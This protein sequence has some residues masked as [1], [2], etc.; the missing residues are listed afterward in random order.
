MEKNWYPR[1]L[2]APK[3]DTNMDNLDDYCKKQ[4]AT[5]LRPVDPD[6]DICGIG[7]DEERE[8]QAKSIFDVL[9]WNCTRR[10]SENQKRRLW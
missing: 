3:T 2:N 4:C 1:D 5:C 6:C 9:W 10:A 8:E 7:S